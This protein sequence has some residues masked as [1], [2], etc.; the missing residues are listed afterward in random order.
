MSLIFQDD[1]CD[2]SQIPEMFYNLSG[3]NVLILSNNELT[4]PIPDS[5]QYSTSLQQLLMDNNKLSGNLP[6][7]L[8]QLTSKCRQM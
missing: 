1:I 7:N 6:S 8:S 4:G 2:I 3:L 5:L